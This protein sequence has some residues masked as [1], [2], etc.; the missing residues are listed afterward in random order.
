MYFSEF[1]ATNFSGQGTNTLTPTDSGDFD[2]K[3][4]SCSLGSLSGNLAL[5]SFC[6]QGVPVRPL[7]DTF[8]YSHG[9]SSSGASELRTGG[10]SL[11]RGP[12]LPS[13]C[14]TERAKAGTQQSGLSLR[15]RTFGSDH[16]L[17]GCPTPSSP[18][19]AVGASPWSTGV[20]G[21]GGGTIGTFDL[22]NQEMFST[23]VRTSPAERTLDPRAMGVA[24]APNSSSGQRAPVLPSTAAGPTT[25]P[26]E[27]PAVRPTAHLT[28]AQQSRFV[29]ALE[30]AT[31]MNPQ[32]KAEL[33][34][35]V[36]LRRPM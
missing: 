8:G 22:L 15:E 14:C 25:Q 10:C 4:L 19:G 32:L 12:A 31:D 5:S 33:L 30:G 26:Q 27:A 1:L 13:E 28:E 24:K 34:S 36:H 21:S 35:L 23:A 16:T 9:S 11:E 7:E 20:R 18:G 6:P 17:G 2:E 29:Q 3:T